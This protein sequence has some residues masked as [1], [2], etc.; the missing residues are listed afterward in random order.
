[1]DDQE[2]ARLLI[3]LAI[4]AAE[5]RVFVACEASSGE[6]ALEQLDRC[7]PEVVVLDAMM[8][9]LG[10]LETAARIR[11]LRPD[12]PMILCSAYVDEELERKAGAMGI[13][14]CVSKGQFE[15]IPSAMVEA[16]SASGDDAT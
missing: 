12:Q 13:G 2:D 10:G 9:G 14:I 15:R 16:V 3:R 4:D 7:R 6:E 5:Q 11:R 1:V 8:P